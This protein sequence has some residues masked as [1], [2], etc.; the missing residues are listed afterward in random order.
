MKKSVLFFAALVCMLIQTMSVTAKDRIITSEQLPA[1]AKSF[2]QKNFPG[3]SVSHVKT[4]REFIKTQYEV[5]LDNGV[6]IKIDKHGKWDK[7]NCAFTAVPEGIAPAPIANYVKTHF[8]DAEIVKIDKQHYGYA[9]EL[10]NY[11]DIK[12]DFDGNLKRVAD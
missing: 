2:I 7:V 12:F 11:I 9:V 3:Q 5:C 1:A 6:E 10:S 4:D 8:A